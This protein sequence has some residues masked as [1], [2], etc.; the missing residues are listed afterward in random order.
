MVVWT[1]RGKQVVGE[2]NEALEKLERAMR[3]ALGNTQW[4][5]MR[6]G[7]LSLDPELD[8]AGG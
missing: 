1:E 3:R 6:E 5:A 7:L 8:R 2:G 4:D